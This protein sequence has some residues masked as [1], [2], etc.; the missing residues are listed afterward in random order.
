MFYSLLEILCEVSF[1]VGSGIQKVPKGEKNLWRKTNHA[2]AEFSICMNE[3]W[4]WWY[5]LVHNRNK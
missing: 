4:K 3:C 5:E 2:V 1:L